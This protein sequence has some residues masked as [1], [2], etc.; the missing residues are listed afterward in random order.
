MLYGLDIGGT[1]IEIAI[2]DQRLQLFNKW[3]VP[4][5]VDSYAEFLDAVIA[6]VK[7]ADSL[8]EHQQTEDA[9]PVGFGLPGFLDVDDNVVSA[10]I[11]GINGRPVKRD[12]SARL[13][14]PV[15]FENDV[16]TFVLSEACD[17]ALAR[18]DHGIGLI[19]G[20]GVCGRFY[21][22][23]E[24]YSGRQQV[25]GE[26]GHVPISA[27][28]QQKYDL[29]LRPC[30]CGLQGCLETYLSGPGL[31]WLCQHMESGHQSVAALMQGVSEQEPAALRVFDAHIDCLGSLLAQLTLMYDPDTIVL[32]GGLSNIT[33][34]YPRLNTA[35]RNYL[36]GSVVPPL[37]VPARFGDSSGVR[38]AALI[39]RQAQLETKQRESKQ[40]ESK[41]Q[42]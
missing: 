19:L 36:F 14:R 18:S 28:L 34:I 2:F 8:I 40:R 20:T 39:G 41:Q 6:L 27:H 11:P 23:G 30:G 38:G 24:L 32:G 42:E 29:P 10:N 7:K 15:G 31:L 37:V 26:F 13:S 5:P 9:P 22:N 4:T 35:A 33:D 21:T 25:A 1:K 3:R 16:S 12:L 17:G